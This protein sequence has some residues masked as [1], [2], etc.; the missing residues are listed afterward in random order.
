MPTPHPTATPTQSSKA[1]EDSRTLEQ[2]EQ[3]AQELRAKIAAIEEVKKGKL[4]AEAEK[5]FNDV[6]AS[7]RQ[8]AEHFNADQVDEIVEEIYE[9]SASQ[10]ASVTKK[11]T[12]KTVRKS[13]AKKIARNVKN[14]QLPT[15]ETYGGK[16]PTPQAFK[17]WAESA[18]G[19]KWRDQNPGQKWPS[20]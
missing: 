11:T 14:Y 3:E 16:G 4:A 17:D 12:K 2:L 8:F 19:K 15:G 9:R 7:I 10:S 5:A 18:A 6:L 1:N 13:A 20:A